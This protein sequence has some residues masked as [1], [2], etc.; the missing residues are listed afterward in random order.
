MKKILAILLMVSTTIYAQQEPDNSENSSTDPITFDDQTRAT[1]PTKPAVIN[2]FTPLVFNPNLTPNPTQPA[3]VAYVSDLLV[4]IAGATENGPFGSVQSTINQINAVNNH[5]LGLS[6]QAATNAQSN[7]A[8]SPMQA[9]PNQIISPNQAIMAQIAQN[10]NSINNLAQTQNPLSPNSQNPSP[11]NPSAAVLLANGNSL[12][13]AGIAASGQAGG[14]PASFIQQ[15][16]ALNQQA[17]F[18]SATNQSNFTA[19][20]TT[21]STIGTAVAT[22]AATQ[23]AQAQQQINAI[24]NPNPFVTINDPTSEPQIVTWNAPLIIDYANP[25]FNTQSVVKFEENIIYNPGQNYNYPTPYV[26]YPAA[27]II[28]RDN[29]TI[30]LA[31][32]NL[33]LA[34]R[35]AASF[36]A[37]KPTYGIAIMPGVKNTK[38]ISSSSLLRPGSISNFSGYAIYGLG[39]STSQSYNFYE[40]MIQNIIIE[41]ILMNSNLGGIFLENA[42]Q[43]A[44]NLVAVS[45]SF[46]NRPISAIYLNNALNGIVENCKIDQNYSDHSVIGFELIDTINVAIDTCIIDSNRSLKDGDAIGVL[47]SATPDLTSYSNRV[48][49]CNII[50]MLCSFTDSRE[51]SGISITGGSFGNIIENNSISFNSHGPGLLPPIITPVTYGIKLS[52]TDFNIIN[53]NKVANNGDFGIY[54]SNATPVTNPPLVPP[55]SISTSFFTNNTCLFQTTNYWVRVPTVGT[56]APG[57]DISLF[58]VTTIYAGNT[59]AYVPSLP[60]LQNISVKLF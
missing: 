17:A 11:Q 32:F 50:N 39:I 57:V 46:G 13:A 28:A 38:I 41:N 4:Y 27:I 51:S 22:N 3:H 1:A 26:D 15:Q 53:K 43:F 56:F 6:G 16:N 37:F 21:A 18:A 9:N 8:P 10:Q 20:Q 19:G 48:S 47:M 30:D 29:I 52:N 25:F 14:P 5:N 45:Y 35:S 36:F 24:N 60:V 55:T 44:I 33:S 23:I 34:P 49:N 40:L 12:I 42:V 2:F 59:S 58:N 54:D 7:A 31:G